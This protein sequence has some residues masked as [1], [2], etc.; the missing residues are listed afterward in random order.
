MA[1]AF[2]FLDRDGVINEDSDDYIK[3]ADEWHAIPGSIEAIAKLSQANYQVFVITNQSGLGRGLFDAL[4]LR[5]MH[6]K[7]QQ[8]VQQAGGRIHG[9]Y[10]C[11]HKP[12]DNCECRKPKP[13]LLTQ[14]RDETGHDLTQAY[15]VGDSLKDLEVAQAVGAKGVLVETGKGKKTLAK[16]KAM[17]RAGEETP[18]PID[19]EGLSPSSTNIKRIHPCLADFVECLLNC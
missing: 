12:E 7:M 18:I 17:H 5:N 1:Q 3:S 13:G 4:A 9:I 19:S 10:Y 6:A 16:L 14:I 11:P 2:I 15:F 8:L